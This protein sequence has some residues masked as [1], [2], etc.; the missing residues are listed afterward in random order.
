MTTVKIRKV[1]DLVIVF[2]TFIS[3]QGGQTC[4]LRLHMTLTRLK[5]GLQ[6][7]CHLKHC[8][9]LKFLQT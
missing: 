6:D 2:K 9:Y 4:G 1:C 3:K 7:Y 8:L 5:Y